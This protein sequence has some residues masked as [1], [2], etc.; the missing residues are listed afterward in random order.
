MNCGACGRTCGATQRCEG[1][2]CVC[3]AGQTACGTSCATTATDVANCGA[4][5]N[6]CA[7]GQAC[8]MGACA[9]PA[10]QT[11]CGAGAA[12]RCLNTATDVNHCGRCG[13]ACAAGESCVGGVCAAV[14]ANDRR[15]G[16]ITLSLDASSTTVTADTTGA[17]NDTTGP[18]GCSCTAGRDVFFRFTLT[19]EEIVYADTLDERGWDSSLFLQDAAGANL[20]AQ[21]GGFA[22]CND[23]ACGAFRSQLAA[24]LAPGTYFLV[25]SGCA[26]GGATI[27]F[28]HLPVG[29]GDVEAITPTGTRTLSGSIAAGAGRVNPGCNAAGP[30]DTYWWTTCP[31]FA[32]QPMHLTT[33][34]GAAFDTVIHQHSAGRSP[35]SFCNDDSCGLQSN[36]LVTLPAGAGLHAYY[37]DVF[38]TVSPGAY[39]VR[40]AFGACFTGWG[41]CGAACLDLQGDASNCGACGR[42][43]TGGQT[44]QTG[45]CRCPTGQT[46]CGS[47]CR[48]T[49]VDPSNCGAC[50]ATCAAG[51]DCAAGRCRFGEGNS[52]LNVATGTVTLNDV[53][54]SV[55]GARGAR[56]VTLANAVG[57][58]AIVAGDQLVLHQTQAATGPVGFYEYRR[59]MSVSG[60]TVTLDEPLAHTYTT[61]A[62]SRAQA[63]VVAEYAAVTVAAGATLTARAWDGNSGGIL[64]LDATGTV[65]VNGALHTNGIGF[66]GRNHACPYRCGRGFQG[67]ST[68]GLGG[69]DIV[70]NG[71]GG[72]GGGRGQDDGAGGGGAYGE[73]GVAG[74]NRPGCGACAEC[75]MGAIPGGAGGV[76]VGSADLS[77][78]LLFGAA[79]GEGGADE[80]GGNPGAGGHG[81]GIVL[82]RAAGVTLGAT[83]V[84]QSNGANGAGGN[85][86]ACGGSGCGM[87]GG[88]GGAGGAVRLLSIGPMMLG[89][90]QVRATGGLGGGATCGSTSG[91]SGSVGRVGV[92]AATIAGST[93]PLYSRN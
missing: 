23:D 31:S 10:G 51:A 9:C 29:S 33:C 46:L 39:T 78:T 55:S 77:N 49:L 24:R 54:A 66:R 22:T 91:G 80:D 34:G 90:N 88:G 16:A 69:A 7:M 21:S 1:G 64:A 85:Q 76:V 17:S 86:G 82:L 28:Q 13:R 72:G 92:R 11:V 4:C 60:A 43:C 35:V 12:A 32:A 63:V 2:A 65:T 57:G 41:V 26:Q 56:T 38:G 70:A 84:I 83:G 68:L 93:L 58:R 59:V 62:T 48:D 14:P 89:V 73:P 67:E 15:A 19:A 74:P 18:M 6:A 50:G 71:A 61:D 25:L 79:G 20:A 75:V 53:A 42:S 44:C 3:P 5:G 81:G 47:T 52:P 36:L 40:H 8:A 37:V 27:R 87:G 45:A 30:E